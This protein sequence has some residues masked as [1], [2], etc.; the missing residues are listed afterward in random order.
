MITKKIISSFF[1]LIFPISCL[2]CNKE[3]EW[4][5]N[6]CLRKIIWQPH[7]KCLNCGEIN[8]SG[9][10]CKDCSLYYELDGLL[11]ASNY[12]GVIK[13][14]IKTCKYNFA[15]PVG[16][17]LGNLLILFI[18]SLAGQRQIHPKLLPW[19]NNLLVPVP[20]ARKRYNWRGFNQAKVIAEQFGNY[21]NLEV[22]DSLHR[23][24]RKAQAT[25][26]RQERRQNL[27]N[28]FSWTGED[29]IGK[30]IILIDD[31]ATTGVT[32]NECAKALKKKRA[33][34]VWGLVIAK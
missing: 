24:H 7:Q 15:E 10:F 25:L 11:S 8:Q 20:L 26:S 31:V 30:N 2:A 4:L 32:L 17:V 22:V 29:L 18:G 14:L 16:K 5:C 28:I 33:K 21:F 6:D 27:K 13:D 12:D 9:E 3:G 34:Q 23:E 19:S 1:D